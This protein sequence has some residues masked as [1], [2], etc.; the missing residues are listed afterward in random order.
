MRTSKKL[1]SAVLALCMI[2]SSS[3]VTSFAAVA[4]NEVGAGDYG[5]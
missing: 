1:V 5:V 4:D 2:A 3:I